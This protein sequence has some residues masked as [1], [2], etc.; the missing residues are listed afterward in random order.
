MVEYLYSYAAKF[1]LFKYILFDTTVVSMKRRN[2][3]HVLILRDGM[4]RQAEVCCDAVAVCAGLH[5]VPDMPHVI[6]INEVPRVLHS[7]EVKS[8][9]QFGVDTNVVILGAGETAMDLAYLAVT[10]PTKSVTVCHR[11]GF[12]CGPK[13]S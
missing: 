7:S 9:S 2:H 11:D 12:F 4:D 1:D 6:G 13:V 8:R 5:V 3:G 10:S